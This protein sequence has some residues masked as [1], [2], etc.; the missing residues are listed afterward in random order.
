M[1]S[2]RDA[3]EFAD[4]DREIAEKQQAHTDNVE[5]VS[6]FLRQNRGNCLLDGFQLPN[7]F[8]WQALCF[9]PVQVLAQQRDW[10]SL[11]NTFHPID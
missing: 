1:T 6:C 9:S 4:E 10:I 2:D 5:S 3:A 7:M 11:K 8:H